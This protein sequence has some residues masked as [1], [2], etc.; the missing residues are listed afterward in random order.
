MR[1]IQFREAICE[2][3]SEEMRSDDS[4]YLMGEEVAEYNGAY[5]ASKGMLDEFGPE[6]VIDTPISELG[7]AGIAIGSTMTG[8][9]PIVEYMTFNFSLVGI[10]QIIN[11]AAKIRQ[12]SGGQFK[13]PIVFRGPTASA[14]QLAATHSQAFENW[15]ANTPG[16]KVIVP[17]NP[18]DAKGLLKSAIRDDDPVIFMESE[19]MYG[20]K[21]EIPEGEYILPI[22]VA[23]IKRS[24][25]DV[26]V[27]SFG[28]I[29]KEAYKAADSLEKEGISIEI[30][31]LRTV[32]PLDIKTVIDSVK[33]T[34]RLVI[35]E[36]AWPF[37]N[38]STEITYQVQEKAF[39]YLDAPVVKIN[40]A[41]TPAPY[42][43][44]LLQEWLPNSGDVIK[45]VKKVLYK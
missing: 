35:L 31:D 7:F 27:V 36:E 14:G 19:Q 42:S 41:D 16:L 45:A 38:V 28:K 20:D 25:S 44:V 23:D 18:Y 10:D 9:R 4:I 5:K 22:G 17:S 11:N 12:M 39:D 33:K 37:G 24:G 32:C 26:T 6:R 30:I 21:G 2:A 1:T 3:M 8:N 40:T 43:P 15:F 34:N 13:C 29:I